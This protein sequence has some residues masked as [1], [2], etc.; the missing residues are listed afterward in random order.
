MSVLR[1]VI[2][3]GRDCL[4]HDNCMFNYLKTHLILFRR[5]LL[6]SVVCQTTAPLLFYT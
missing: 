1:F 3:K 2:E 6:F 5:S 4:S